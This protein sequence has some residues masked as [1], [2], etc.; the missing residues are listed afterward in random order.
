MAAKQRF[1]V[2]SGNKLASYYNNVG[3]DFDNK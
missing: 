2:L 1:A 3:D